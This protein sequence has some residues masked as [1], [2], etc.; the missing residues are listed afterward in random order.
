MSSLFPALSPA[1]AGAP[2]DRPALRFG[3]R[4]LTYAELAA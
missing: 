1:P 4:S 3:E 2:G